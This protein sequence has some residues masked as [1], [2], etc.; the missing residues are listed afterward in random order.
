MRIEIGQVISQ[1]ISF[2]IMLWVL[3]R[4]AWKPLL[5]VMDERRQKIKSEFDSI[6]AQKKELAK[7]IDEYNK[8]LKE[9]DSLAKA[10]EQEGIKK[11]EFAAIEIQ[12]EARSHAKKIILKAEE[13]MFKE[14][15][16]AKIQLKNDLVNMTLSASEKVLQMNLDGEKQKHLIED[17]VKQTEFN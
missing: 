16:K 1:I 11:G 4:F 6:E 15:A 14:I 13:N 8:K 7:L 2:L 3:K 10:K 12:N 5:N 9:I 17:F